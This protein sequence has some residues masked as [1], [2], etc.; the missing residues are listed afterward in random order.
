MNFPHHCQCL[1]IPERI[2]LNHLNLE[3]YSSLRSLNLSILSL[4]VKWIKNCYGSSV[5][6]NWTFQELN[7][8]PLVCC[9]FR[10]RVFLSPY[11][12]PCKAGFNNLEKP[13][14]STWSAGSKSD[15]GNINFWITSRLQKCYVIR[16]LT[17]VACLTQPKALLIIDR[18][19]LFYSYSSSHK[20]LEICSTINSEE[21]KMQQKC[22]LILHNCPSVLPS[23]TCY[24]S[25]NTG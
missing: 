9:L 5:S 21:T 16:K 4:M 23:S 18:Y 11:G 7:L 8:A 17:N 24:L 22:E 1:L 13:M 6:W 15:R 20:L 10:N 12:N 25:L 2:S 19:P 14:S 3:A